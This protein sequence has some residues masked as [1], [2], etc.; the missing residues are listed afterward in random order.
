MLHVMCNIAFEAVNLN[1]EAR[2]PRGASMTG[3]IKRG[4][5]VHAAPLAGKM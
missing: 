3:V 5:R 2:L 4:S 1:R